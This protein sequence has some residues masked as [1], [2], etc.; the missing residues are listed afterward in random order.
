MDTI[1]KLH[2]IP[3]SLD[4]FKE[5][6]D[7]LTLNAEKGV[8]AEDAKK[9]ADVFSSSRYSEHVFAER[10]SSF[11]RATWALGFAAGVEFNARF[12]S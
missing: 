4:E 5:Y 9:F 1:I 6:L 3:I 8:T 11:V 7:Y 10:D 2:N 12:S